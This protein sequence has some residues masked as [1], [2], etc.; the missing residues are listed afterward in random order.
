M[1]E[2]SIFHSGHGARKVG[3][4]SRYNLWLKPSKLTLTART[5]K[6]VLN[7]KKQEAQRICKTARKH[8]LW[9]A[10]WQVY[11]DVK[12]LMLPLLI[13]TLPVPSLEHM[14]HVQGVIDTAL[15]TANSGYLYRRLDFTASPVVVTWC[16]Q[17]CKKTFI[18]LGFFSCV[19]RT[20]MFVAPMQ[21]A[22]VQKL[23]E[24]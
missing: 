3:K 20:S 12:V 13:N 1:A 18:F 5:T 9:L 8:D 24:S 16:R 2:G 21:I 17:D 23:G 15:R 4:L 19:K 6:L 22:H 11:T 14:W 7:V 10:R